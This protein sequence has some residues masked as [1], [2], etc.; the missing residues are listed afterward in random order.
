MKKLIRNCRV[1]SAD[2]DMLGASIELEDSKIKAVYE[3][4][5]LLPE[6]DEVFD[7]E[8]RMAMP[9][10]IDIHSHGAMGYDFS[11]GTFEAVEAITEAKLKEGVTTLLPTTLTIPQEQL[12]AA[13][14]AVA[15][16][17]ENPR[18]VKI[19]G[20]HLEGP[21]IN[22][23]FLGAQNPD[24]VR[25]PDIEE[26][27]SLN[28]IM[29]IAIVSMAIDVDGALSVIKELKKMGIV[30]S[31][32]HCGAS[33]AQFKDAKEAGLK[34]ITHFCNQMSPV[35]HREI[36]LVGSGFMD[37]D[38]ILELICDRIHL[39][40]DMIRLIFKTKA[41]EKLALITDSVLAS[42]MP[43]GEY[44]LG[45]LDIRVSDGVARLVSNDALAGSTLLLWQGIR[46]VH[47]VTGLPLSTLVKTTSLNQAQSMGFDGLGKIAAGYIADIV[48]LDDDFKPSAVFVDGEQ[49]L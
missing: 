8:G 36:G 34:H 22:L 3:A 13:C 48:I 14:A 24:A 25:A 7:A 44:Q 49:R 47:E 10:F 23:S 45:G 9:G 38:I 32:A 27:K 41:V 26:V 12:K 33:Y 20:M 5:V 16:Y 28:E 18:F 46:N 30:T 15:Q 39:C 43:D 6:V 35:H 11:D 29:P 1:I 31:V 17:A 37:D 21:F 40:D 4:G 2:I 42:A 19:P